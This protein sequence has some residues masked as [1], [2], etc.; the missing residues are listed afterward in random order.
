MADKF[1]SL[2]YV[3]LLWCFLVFCFLNL[4]SR[5]M[6]CNFGYW[7]CCTTHLCELDWWLNLSIFTRKMNLIFNGPCRFLH[8]DQ[9]KLTTLWVT[10]TKG[11]RPTVWTPGEAWSLHVLCCLSQHKIWGY[12]AVN[13]IDTMKQILKRMHRWVAID[14]MHDLYSSTSMILVIRFNLVYDDTY[15]SYMPLVLCVILSL[16]I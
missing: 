5:E 11:H 8:S 7:L 1:L 13:G 3:C 10:S 9:V 15:A 2:M 16:Q 12:S 4:E 14:K 6:T